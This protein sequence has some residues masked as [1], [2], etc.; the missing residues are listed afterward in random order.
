MMTTKNVSR[1]CQMSPVGQR[2]QWLRIPGLSCCEA[3]SAAGRFPFGAL[4]SAE[5]TPPG[6]GARSARAQQHRYLF[7]TMRL[8]FRRA[9]Y[10]SSGSADS[11][12]TRG[13]AS[14]LSSVP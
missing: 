4:F 7:C 6:P 8:M 9:T 13:G 11:S 1:R 5:A 12:V 3:L 2:Y 10:C 14:F